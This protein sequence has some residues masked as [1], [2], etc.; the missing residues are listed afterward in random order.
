[1]ADLKN[2]ALT[3]VCSS[4][5]VRAHL[6]RDER[7]PALLPGQPGRPV[8]EGGGSGHHGRPGRQ[9]AV[10]FVVGTLADDRE[11]NGPCRCERADQAVDIPAKRATVGRDVS[12]VDEYPKCHDLMRSL[13][14]PIS[15]KAYALPG[16]G[17]ASPV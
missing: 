10:P 8:P 9:P 11:V 2:M 16:G 14:S 6:L 15:S 1:M 13:R 17:R 7:Q 3:A 4:G 5:S 12:R